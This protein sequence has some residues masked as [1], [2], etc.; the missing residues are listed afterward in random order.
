M[1]GYRVDSTVM[2]KQHPRVR[3]AEKLVDQ[4]IKD[5]IRLENV[6][7][8]HPSEEAAKALHDAVTRK[9]E[10]VKVMADTQLDVQRQLSSPASVAAA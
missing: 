3:A 4:A 8:E 10:A 1:R 9:R 6:W 2:A 7:Y 5:V